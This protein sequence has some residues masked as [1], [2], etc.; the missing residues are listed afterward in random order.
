MLNLKVNLKSSV[1]IGPDIEILFLRTDHN[2]I[3]VAIQAPKL[4]GI[5]R[6][7]QFTDPEIRA[8]LKPRQ[9]GQ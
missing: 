4:L 2:Q 6:T 8:K 1:L 5:L 3:S 7:Q 9:S